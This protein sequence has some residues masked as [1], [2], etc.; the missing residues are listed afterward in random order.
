[1]NDPKYAYPY[2]P[3]RLDAPPEPVIPSGSTDLGGFP[4]SNTTQEH[5]GTQVPPPSES[6][7]QILD[8]FDAAAATTA[9]PSKSVAQAPPPPPLDAPPE[10]IIPRNAQQ[11]DLGLPKLVLAFCLTAAFEIAFRSVQTRKHYPITFQL[12]CLLMVF[13]LAFL[14]VAKYI[15]AKYPKSGRLLEH[16]GLLCG[17]TAFFAAITVSFSLCLKLISWIVYALSL[18]AISICNFPPPL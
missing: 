17:V 15:V 13:A 11:Q 5:L 4:A 1:M 8:H 16:A 2:P 14:V 9:E 10:P 7:I 12:L 6:M 3:P 18:L